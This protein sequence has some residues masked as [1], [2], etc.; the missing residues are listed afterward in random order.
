MKKGCTERKGTATAKNRARLQQQK[1]ELKEKG[2]KQRLD[3]EAEERRAF[4]DLIKKNV[5]I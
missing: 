3:L 4:I 2:R 5:N 1:W